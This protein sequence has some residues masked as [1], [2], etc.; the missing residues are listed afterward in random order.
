MEFFAP[1]HIVKNS[2]PFKIRIKTSINYI[3]NQFIF[4]DIFQLVF[5]R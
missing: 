2:L 4:R 3:G 5:Y 1:V